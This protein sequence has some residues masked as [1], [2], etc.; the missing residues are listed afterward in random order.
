MFEHSKKHFLIGVFAATLSPGAYADVEP[1]LT[2]KAARAKSEII[3]DGKSDDPAWQHSD[4]VTSM[5]SLSGIPLSVRASY[6]DEFIYML[7]SFPDPEASTT[8]KSLSWN[9]EQKL[10]ET[11]PDREDTLVI[12]WNM[13]GSV[14]DLRLDGSSPYRSDVWFWKAHRTNPSGYA[15]DKYQIYSANHT[16]NSHVVTTKEGRPFY[17]TR[18]GDQG[19]P[20]YRLNIP[21]EYQGNI[22]SAYKHVTPSG[23]RADIKA[24]GVW[25]NGIWTIEFKRKLNTHQPDDVVIKTDSDTTFAI[26]RYEIAGRK[27][28]NNLSQPFYG[29]GEVGPLI[30]LIME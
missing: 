14:S 2:L 24:K 22:I 28:N 10:Y 25:D 29:A 5:D 17:L 19:S 26:S 8:H 4:S 7:I 9:S 12:K 16:Q 11:A 21:H 1:Q 30:K 13:P 23:S 27:V 15:D 6:D 18:K 3:I 20:A